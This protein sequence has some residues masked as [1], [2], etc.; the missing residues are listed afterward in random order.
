MFDG[1]S[2]AVL[3]EGAT[4]ASLAVGAVCAFGASGAWA[5]EVVARSLQDS[6]VIE[7]RTRRYF[8]FVFVCDLSMSR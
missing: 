4:G 8:M 3:A 7:R 1:V 2:G 5:L 6:M